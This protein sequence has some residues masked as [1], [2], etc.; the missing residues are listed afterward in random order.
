MS[1]SRTQRRRAERAAVKDAA[2]RL[3]LASLEPG[4]TGERPISVASA[5][6]IE[7]RASSQPCVVCGESV[8]VASTFCDAGMRDDA[9][10]FF[11]SKGNPQS[12]TSR[13]TMERINSCID[14]KQQQ[15]RKLSAWMSQHGGGS[16]AR[17]A[18]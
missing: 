2:R 11:A 9:K 4:G 6:V 10:Q 16:K 18:K 5:S 3:K 7:P 12:R 14:L 15:Q 17:V 8:R 13:Q 1:R